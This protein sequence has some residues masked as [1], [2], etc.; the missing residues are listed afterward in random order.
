[1]QTMKCNEKVL[2]VFYIPIW[3]KIYMNDFIWNNC[4]KNIQNFKLVKS[5]CNLNMDQN[6]LPVIFLTLKKFIPIG[7]NQ[8]KQIINWQWL[9]LDKL[10]TQKNSFERVNHMCQSIFLYEMNIILMNK[11]LSVLTLFFLFIYLM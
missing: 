10:K 11:Y 4:Y 2:D 9:Y 7:K 1:M 3:K 6:I 5:I 8:F